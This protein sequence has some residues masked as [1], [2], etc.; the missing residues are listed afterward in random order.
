MVVA[1]LVVGAVLLNWYIFYRLVRVSVQRGVER[2]NRVS[3]A[4]MQAQ[5]GALNQLVG[6]L[7]KHEAPTP[8]AAP[9]DDTAGA[10]D[11]LRSS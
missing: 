2:A 3:E 9:A 11:K 7:V 10:W 6:A 5:L 8:K 1:V 4:I